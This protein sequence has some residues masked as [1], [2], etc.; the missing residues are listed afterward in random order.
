MVCAGGVGAG[1]F[2]VYNF[3]VVF[4]E[5]WSGGS[6]FFCAEDAED[7][8]ASGGEEGGE[9]ASGGEERKD[10]VGEDGDGFLGAGFGDSPGL[11]VVDVFIDLLDFA[12]DEIEGFGEFEAVHEAGVFG[13][14]GGV[15]DGGG[16]SGGEMDGV[17]VGEDGEALDEVTEVVGEFAGVGGVEFVP[18]EV[19]VSKGVDVAEKVVAEGVEAVFVEDVE[20]V[21][22][23]AEGFR[24]FLAVD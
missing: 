16:E 19:G 7:F 17:F 10:E 12:P 4:G 24:H 9:E 3:T 1:F 13:A 15:L 2:S 8:L 14:D 18:S 6:D 20:W 22:D 21:D 5:E 23:V 11:L